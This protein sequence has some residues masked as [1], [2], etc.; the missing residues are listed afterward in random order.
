MEGP[1]LCRPEAKGRLRVEQPAGTHEEVHTLLCR[2]PA[3]TPNLQTCLD[4]LTPH[5]QHHV[6][7]ATEAWQMIYQSA[8]FLSLGV[9][10]P[11]PGL[12]LSQL[13]DKA[14]SLEL[15]LHSQSHVEEDQW[16]EPAQSCY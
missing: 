10:R 14:E 11:C 12:V 5:T 13:Q 7:R 6:P 3:P 9:V 8:L 15:S 2:T 16:E 1:L 4:I